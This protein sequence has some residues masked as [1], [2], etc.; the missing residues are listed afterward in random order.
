[1]FLGQPSY[2]VLFGNP[3]NFPSSVSLDQIPSGKK[4]REREYTFFP[5]ILRLLKCHPSAQFDFRF[6]QIFKIFKFK[7]EIQLLELSTK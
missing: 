7:V 4:I 2:S 6:S 3:L 5:Y 1:M